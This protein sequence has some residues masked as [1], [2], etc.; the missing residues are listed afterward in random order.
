MTMWMWHMPSDGD[1][2]FSQVHSLG[3]YMGRERGEG[4][5]NRENMDVVF[6]FSTQQIESQNWNIQYLSTTVLWL[7]RVHG[8]N[9]RPSKCGCPSL[10]LPHGD[11]SI[12]PCGQQTSHALVIVQS[13]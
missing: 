11:P 6:I 10:I 8:C 13:N 2:S 4:L 3:L 1:G 5:I 9:V 7:Y 12:Y